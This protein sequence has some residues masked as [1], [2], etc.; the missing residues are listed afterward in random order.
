MAQELHRSAKQVALSVPLLLGAYQDALRSGSHDPQAL[1]GRAVAA[2]C[3]T[4]YLVTRPIGELRVRSA[5][6]DL[7]VSDVIT[8]LVRDIDLC[9]PV[10]VVEDG[11][12]SLERLA[13]EQVRPVVQILS[14]ALWN[15]GRH[16]GATLVLLTCRDDGHEGVISVRD[17]GRGFATHPRPGGHGLA[18]M[19][20]DAASIGAR[21]EIGSVIGAGTTLE[22]RVPWA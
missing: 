15:A 3:Q 11:S 20:S 22:V 9:L 17:D 8:E 10:Q 5:D 6:A 2:A 7:P 4:S 19:Y 1:L 13:P 21:L 16:S 14:E 18:Q 12:T